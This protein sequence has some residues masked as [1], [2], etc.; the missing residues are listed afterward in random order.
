MPGSGYGARPASVFHKQRNERQTSNEAE[1][2]IDLELALLKLWDF[3]SS[4]VRLREAEPNKEGIRPRLL[5]KSLG[6]LCGG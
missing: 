6:S 2:W 1:S 3:G 4:V 5:G